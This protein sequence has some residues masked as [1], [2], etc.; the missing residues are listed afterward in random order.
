MK[1]LTLLGNIRV[2]GYD[3]IIN[4]IYEFHGDFWHGNPAVYKA[5]DFNIVRKETFANLYL[6]TIKR[7]QFI[8]QNGYNLVT[9]WESDWLLNVK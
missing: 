3:P 7:D 5:D 1:K 9:I 2:D 8:I 4:T 6:Q